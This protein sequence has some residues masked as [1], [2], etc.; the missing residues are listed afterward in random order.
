MFWRAFWFWGQ[1]H[2][3]PTLPIE[4]NLRRLIPAGTLIVVGIQII[5]SSFF[6]SVL[7]LKTVKRQP[8]SPEP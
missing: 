6:I 3:T 5:F 4:E 2:F 8:P 1:V 7:G